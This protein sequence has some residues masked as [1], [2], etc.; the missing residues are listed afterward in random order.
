[1]LLVLFPFPTPL[2]CGISE[3][4]MSIP[5]LLSWFPLTYK[6]FWFGIPSQ[7]GGFKKL[8]RGVRGFCDIAKLGEP[9]MS[10]RLLVDSAI[11]RLQQLRQ[12]RG[13]HLTTP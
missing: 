1:M 2:V 4:R 12:I 3:E 10:A 6:L 9:R 8:R 13:I 5:Q 7:L 11:K